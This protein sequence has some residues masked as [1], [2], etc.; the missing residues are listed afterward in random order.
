VA[1]AAALTL[2]FIVGERQVGKTSPMA[3]AF[4][5]ML[6]ACGFW[7]IFS[8]WWEMDLSRFGQV[9]SLGGNLAAVDVPLVIPLAASLVGGSFFSFYFSFKALSHLP[10]T[11][12][13]IV[14]ASEVIFAFVVA[15]LW[16]GEALTLSQ[17]LGALL[18]LA[19]IVVAQTARPGT[20]LDLDL[21]MTKPATRIRSFPARRHRESV[22]RS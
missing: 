17:S 6:F 4:W 19:G 12:A 22:D 7:A 2:Y 21:A 11:A 3:V 15:W 8:G 13:G 10:A 16:L 1:A 9:V 14:A 5:S 20:V 18:V